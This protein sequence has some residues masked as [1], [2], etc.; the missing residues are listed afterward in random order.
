MIVAL[1][2]EGVQLAPVE[3]A[4]RA[5]GAV[6]VPADASRVDARRVAAFTR[7]FTLDALIGLHESTLAGL[8]DLGLDS[9]LFASVGLV[10]A[11][12]GALE[13][14]RASGREVFRCALLGPTLALECRARAGLHVDGVSWA[15]AVDDGEIVLLPRAHV[16]GR[17]EHVATGTKGRVLEGAC[18]CGRSDPRVVPES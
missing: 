9:S 13:T 14:M 7:D 15:V 2:S 6:P 11:R 17:P 1:I 8:H 4:V 10:F 5:L 3:D 12:P 18:P 16:A